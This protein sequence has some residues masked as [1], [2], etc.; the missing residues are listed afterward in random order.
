M[1]KLDVIIPVYKAKETIFQTLS[2]VAIQS[3][4][5]DINVLMVVDA[6]G[7]SYDD[8]YHKFEGMFGDFTIYYLAENGGPA[9]ARQFGLDHSSS[10]YVAFID[11]DDTFAGAF[12]LE[13]LMNKLEV[14]P[15]II[16][17]SSVFYEKRKD[18]SFV[19][20]ERDMVW[21]HGK[22]YRRS[23]LDKWGIRFNDTRAN[24]DVGF[25]TK[26][27][28]LENENERILF[29][30]SMTYYWHWNSTGITRVNELSYTYTDSYFGYVDNQIDAIHHAL[31]YLAV[32]D[33]FLVGYALEVLVHGYIYIMRIRYNR[34]ELEPKAW[35]YARK[36]YNEVIN[37]LDTS[38]ITDENFTEI[39][40]RTI[41]GQIGHFRQHIIDMTFHEY[42]N[43]LLA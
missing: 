35:D 20:H 6:D 23:F 32:N 37:A 28:L 3:I 33:T 13:I 14:D 16:M 38:V 4:A 2:S 7:Y 29:V 26:I 36:Y 40:A 19:K 9:V 17:V 1:S 25:N 15:K 24:E 39:V 42:M 43:I 5:K 22:V 27:K 10:P 31:K 41:E 11:A 12:A 18:L 30:D 21:L 34:P 8:L